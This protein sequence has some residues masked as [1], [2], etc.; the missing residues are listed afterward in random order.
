MVDFSWI[1]SLSAD[2]KLSIA[3][4][5]HTDA[6]VLDFLSRDRDVKVRRAVSM[7]R[8]TS[9]PTMVKLVESSI[10]DPGTLQNIA[11]ECKNPE[12]L[13]AVGKC[14]SSRVLVF[15]A[16][17]PKTPTN[18]L[19]DLAKREKRGI[20]IHELYLNPKTPKEVKKQL[21]DNNVIKRLLKTNST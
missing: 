13:R 19:T 3:S 1:K 8:G 15:L 5:I 11:I 2:T 4:D 18:V 14:R 10:D 20:V 16:R 21:E 7:N 9:V 6:E 12:V 17:N